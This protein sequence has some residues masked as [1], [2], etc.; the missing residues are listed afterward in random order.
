M[1]Q[2]PF[3][4]IRTAEIPALN[5]EM[6]EYRHLATNA[7]HYHLRSEDTNNAFLVA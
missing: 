3:E 5:V 2:A 6:Q 4:L 1:T 7:R